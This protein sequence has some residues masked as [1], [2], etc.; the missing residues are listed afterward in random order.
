MGFWD[1]VKENPKPSAGWLGIGQGYSYD[2]CRYRR[3]SHCYFSGIVDERA[4]KEIGYRVHVPV[5]RGH[6]FHITWASQ[7]NCPA[8]QPGPH[9]VGGYVDATVPWE[10]GGQRT[11]ESSAA[12]N[13]IPPRS[14]LGSVSRSGP[15]PLTQD[16]APVQE[17]GENAESA[18]QSEQKAA[19]MQSHL[20]ALRTAGIV[21][22]DEYEQA[23]GRIVRETPR[24]PTPNSVTQLSAADHLRALVAAGILTPPEFELYCSRL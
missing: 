21:S 10:A 19:Q 11:H 8:S 2:W 4:S 7:E 3:Y 22:S 24:I 6:C 5:D 23:A 1:W 16:E 14:T 20:L 17:R 13:Y 12:A 9:V 18:A 15:A